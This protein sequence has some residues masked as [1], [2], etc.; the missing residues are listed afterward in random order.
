MTLEQKKAVALGNARLRMGSVTPAK[1]D[2]DFKP[3]LAEDIDPRGGE[4]LGTVLSGAAAEPV[5]GLAGLATLPFAGPEAAAFMVED[6]RKRLTSIPE[7]PEGMARLQQVG[8]LLRPAGEVIQAAEKGAGELAGGQEAPIKAA[9][10]TTAPTAAMTALGLGGVRRVLGISKVADTAKKL[11]T[12]SAKKLLKE[13]APT[14]DGLKEAAGAVYKEID[15]LGISINPKSV[16]NLA[17]DLGVAVKKEGFNKK[18]HPK[19]NAALTEFNSIKG[20]P[21]TLTEIDTLRKVAKSAADSLDPSEARLGRILLDKIDDTLDSLKS[22]NFTNPSKANIGAKYK[23]AR[24]LWGRAKRSELLEE[25]FSKAE[26]SASGFEKGI[27]SEFRSILNNKKKR[28][29]FTPE[30]ISVMRQVVK[31]GTLENLAKLIGKFGISEGQSVSVFAPSLGAGVGYSVAGPAGA[32]AVPVI[33]QVSK[34][35]A[36]KLTRDAGKGADLIIRA[37]KDGKKVV[38]AY[39]RITKKSERNPQ[40]L[41]ELLLRPEVSLKELKAKAAKLP[42]EDRKLVLDAVYLAGFAQSQK[43]QTQIEEPQPE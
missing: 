25:A 8:E 43:Q 17:N 13:S 11:V 41:T 36:Q 14:I 26:L 4:A 31:G 29:G 32:F 15:D 9:L 30:E 35:L 10:A 12:P 6:I 27:R 24:Q 42:K 39:L 21:Q 23:D 34:V 3:I 40:E 18:I 28:R 16:T 7:T 20:Q 1:E 19:V 33:G 2:Q 5:A 37:G 22:A 38:D